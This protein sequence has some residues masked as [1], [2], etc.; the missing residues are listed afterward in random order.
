[1]EVMMHRFIQQYFHIAYLLSMYS[2]DFQQSCV[3]WKMN[4]AL[5]EGISKNDQKYSLFVAK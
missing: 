2:R 3:A 5:R 1:M 4:L